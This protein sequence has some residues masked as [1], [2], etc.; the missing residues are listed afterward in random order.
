VLRKLQ[1]E[2][3]SVALSL[4]SG[5]VS[6]ETARTLP[7]L[8]AVVKE[9]LRIWPPAVDHAPRVAPPEGDEWNG[10]V[11]PGG[12]ELGWNAWG[13][14]HDREVWGN[15][16]DHFRPERWLDPAVDA[17]RR[18]DMDTVGE[19]VFGG[20]RFQCLGRSVALIEIRK[21]LFEAS[22]IPFR[23]SLSI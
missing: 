9:S 7:Y 13:V 16:A 18:R 15:D 22:V 5:I 4:G 20:G 19:M 12:T 1:V 2:I 11:L 3:D 23:L 6:D 8:S 14:M 10:V 17:D 21:T